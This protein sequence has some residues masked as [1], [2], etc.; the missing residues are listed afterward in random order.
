MFLLSKL[1]TEF[2][3]NNTQKFHC[4]LHFYFKVNKRY[5]LGC[6]KGNIDL[7]GSDL[8]ALQEDVNYARGSGRRSSAEKCQ[9]LC[10]ATELCLFFTYD[11]SDNDCYL[12]S[13]NLGEKSYQGAISGPKRCFKQGIDWVDNF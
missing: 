3:L 9:E 12:K 5:D 7:H 13:A 10:E 2:D 8:N 6:Y 4:T 1:I 11:S